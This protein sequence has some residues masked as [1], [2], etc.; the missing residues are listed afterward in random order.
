MASN[1]IAGT[2]SSRERGSYRRGVSSRGRI[3]ALVA[4]AAAV[5]SGVV[6]VGVLATRNH[7]PTAPKARPGHPPLTLDLGVRTDPEARALRA[8]QRLRAAKRYA[9]AATIFGRYR[10]LEAEVGSALAEQPIAAASRLQQ[11]QAEHPRSSL[12]ALH[13]GLALYWLR[14]N[15]EALTS[16]QAAA[17]SQPDT[18]YAVRAEDFLHPQY[19]PGLPRFVPSFPMPPRI[20]ALPP[21]TQ[22]AALRRAA[23][24]G[25]AREKLLYGVALQQLERPRS[26]ER[27]F[28]AA[29]SLAPDDP[30]ARVAAAVGLFDKARPARAFSRLGPLTRTFPQAQTVRFHLGLL[31]L[32]SAQVA[33]ARKQLTRARA[34]GLK[35]PLGRQ[36]TE[37]LAALARLGTS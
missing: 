36:A 20:R 1:C 33:E 31:L 18:A 28:A 25:G 2:P 3:F 35:T 15:D 27:Q 13:L 8:A 4:L 29:A 10:S 23:A 21:A 11:L 17:R 24:T 19:A 5:A 6:V 12:V 37:Y 9:A 22:L 7:V 34:E 16:W 30:D 14:R 32:W 26:A